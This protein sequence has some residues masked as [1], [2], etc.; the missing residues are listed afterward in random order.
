MSTIQRLWQTVETQ[1]NNGTFPVDQ[2]EKIDVLVFSEDIENIRNGLTLMTTIAPEYLCRYLV[3]DRDSVVL[4][5]A[6]K[7]SAPLNAERVLVE[8]AKGE[9]M[10][11]ALSESGAFESMEFPKSTVKLISAFKESESERAFCIR[12]AREMVQIFVDE[13]MMG[14]SED[15]ENMDSRITPRH[16]VTLTRDFLIG[17]YPVT[18]AL[19]ESVMGSRLSRFKGANRPV[20]RVRW[21]DAVDFCNKLSELEGLETVYIIG[22]EGVTCNWSAKGYRLPTEAEWEYSARSKQSYKYSG[23]DNIDEVAW[24]INNSGFDT[25]CWSEKFE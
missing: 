9:S 2:L 4:R 1:Y 10:W 11:Q 15:D 12:M 22:D 8:S 5:D 3:L 23:S 16:K 6:V 14:L 18:Q 7:F 25:R 21:F 19:W 24:Y 20:D 17:R 13:F